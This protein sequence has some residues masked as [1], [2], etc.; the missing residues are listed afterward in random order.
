MGH[1]LPYAGFHRSTGF[2]AAAASLTRLI[3]VV[4]GADFTRSGFVSDSFAISSM[5]LIN[6]SSSFRLSVSVGS[7]IRAPETINGNDTVGG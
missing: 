3:R 1:L 6:A 5:A 7:I 4:C 2:L